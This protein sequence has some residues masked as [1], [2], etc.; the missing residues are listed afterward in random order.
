MAARQDFLANMSHELRTPLTSILGFTDL[1]EASWLDGEQRRR[2]G[3]IRD[4][5]T[6]LLETLNDV[7]DF[8]KLEAG[9]MNLDQRPF[10][11][12]AV[13]GKAAGMFEAQAMAKGLDL[14]A[15]RRCRLPRMAGRRQRAPAP[16]A[17][18]LPGQRG[19]VHGRGLGDA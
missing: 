8:S 11:L 16:G 14:T 17:G 6:V 5:G 9:G 13:L 4:A 12:R 19:E 7:L 15:A 1:L 10:E 2:L 18:Q 3:R